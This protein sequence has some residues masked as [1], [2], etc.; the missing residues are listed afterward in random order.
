MGFGGVYVFDLV[1]DWYLLVGDE[2][3]IFVIV[4][5]LEVLFFDVIG[6]V[7]IEVVGLD[8]EIGLIV[9]DVVEVN[10]VYCGGCVDL[11]FE[12]CV[13]DYVLLIEV[14]I[15]IVWLLG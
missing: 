8:D 4:V 3:V 5:V 7:F 2:L 1:V 13:G 12:D 15:I 11:V 9:L 14:V 6:R 10:W